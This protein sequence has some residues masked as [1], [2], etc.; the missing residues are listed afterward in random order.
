M[1]KVKD[2][3]NQLN[4]E[5]KGSGLAH[6]LAIVSPK[7]CVPQKKNARYFTPEKFKRLVSNIAE[8]G[9]ESVPLV[10]RSGT[11]YEIISGHHRIEAAKEAGIELFYV[12]VLD[13]LT[14]DELV[15]RQLS[16]NALTGI[17]DQML[18]TELFESIEDIQER[19]RT[20]LSD[21]IGKIQY[22]SL[23][24][25]VGKWRE[26]TLLFLPEDEAMTDE[27]MAEIAQDVK[28]SESVRIQSEKYWNRFADSIRRIKKV[29][30][31]KSNGIAF[32]RMVELADQK[33]KED[34]KKS[35]A[36]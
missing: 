14:K 31:I 2:L 26:F 12:F 3:L 28:V 13:N 4:K 5:M 32:M 15:S 19:I 8:S 20:G 7:D 34:A 16:H 24:F 6:E 1:E 36:T 25:K 9:M 22:E 11:K 18:L 27:A 10:M 29:E 35:Q 30:N 17:D 33:M 23:N 21:E